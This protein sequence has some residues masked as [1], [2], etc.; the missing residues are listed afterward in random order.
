MQQN[1][2][3]A[4][5]AQDRRLYL[6]SVPYSVS[7]PATIYAKLVREKFTQARNKLVERLGEAN[8]QRHQDI[9]KKMENPKVSPEDITNAG[10]LFHPYSGFFQDSGGFQDSDIGTSVPAQTKYAPSLTSFQSSNIEGERASL[11][12]PREPSEVGAGKPFQCFL[13]SCIVPNV[14]NRV[15]WK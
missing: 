10:F 8:W 14:R 6:T 13:C 2:V 7:G 3:R 4:E 11:R 1:L 12:L 5:T 9:R 15:D